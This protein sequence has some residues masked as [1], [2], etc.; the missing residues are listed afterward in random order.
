MLNYND[1]WNVKYNSY[2]E[3]AME[4]L[5]NKCRLSDLKVG[6][7]AVV[8]KYWKQ[9]NTQT[10]V[11]HGYYK[12]CRNKSKKDSSDGWSYR[13]WAKRLWAMS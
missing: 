8:T 1:K 7:K 13:H 6:Q 4:N 9:R 10:F 3:D 11:R 12:R 5:S 2:K